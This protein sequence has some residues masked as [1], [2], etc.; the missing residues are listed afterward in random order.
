MTIKHG[1]DRDGAT[2]CVVDQVTQK[3]EKLNQTSGL[4]LNRMPRM[5]ICTQTEMARVID[6]FEAPRSRESR[7]V[8]IE[9]TIDRFLKENRR[10]KGN[11]Q[12]LEVRDRQW[13]SQI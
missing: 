5:H 12:G 6:L 10:D 11:V 3:L 13:R 2:G 8:M 4:S 1:L 9:H 7:V